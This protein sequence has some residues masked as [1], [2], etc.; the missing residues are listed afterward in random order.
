MNLKYKLLKLLKEEPTSLEKL[1][2]ELHGVATNPTEKDMNHKKTLSMLT[3]LRGEGWGIYKG[4]AGYI[5]LKEHIRLLKD[6][7]KYLDGTKGLGP[8]RLQRLAGE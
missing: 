2:E 1:A 4:S 7:G 3:V 6:C 8:E 5:L